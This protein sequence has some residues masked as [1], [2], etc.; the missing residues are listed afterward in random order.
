[1]PARAR[2]LESRR[3]G[4]DRDEGVAMPEQYSPNSPAGEVERFGSLADGLIR[5]TGW[6]RTAARVGVFVVLSLPLVLM[7]VSQFH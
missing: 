1:M 3:R 4:P 6:R 7:A 5:L 2:F